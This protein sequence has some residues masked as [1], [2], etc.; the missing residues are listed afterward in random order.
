MV[1]KALVVG[2]YHGKLRELSSLDVDLTVVVPPSWGKQ[3]LEIRRASEY[4]ISILPCAL[5]GFN[6]F[7]YYRM[8]VASI[9][10]DLVHLDEEP[11]S[12]VTYQFMRACVRLHKPIVF[13]TWQNINKRYPPPFNYFEH[14]S[15]KHAQAAIAGNE[16]AKEILESRNFTKPI[17]V[18]PQFG[19]D[20]E[21]FRKRDVGDL[22]KRLGLAGKFSIGYI[23][24]IVPEK[25]AADLIQALA[26]LPEPCVLVL[27]GDGDFQPRAEQLAAQFGV[28]QRVRWVP[29]VSSLDIPDYMN[30]I[31]VLVLPSR[32]TRRWKEQFG[33]VLVEA[34]ACETPVVGSNSAEIP[35]V[36]G[37]AGLVFPEGDV[38]ALVGQLRRLNDNPELTAQWGAQGRA[39]VLENFTHRRIA[40]DTVGLYKQVLAGSTVP[41]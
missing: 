28:T 32:T 17:R 10:A 39:R 16:E 23:G 20:P 25:G 40:E 7:H 19:I 18:I 12:F 37:D 6:H 35:N 11:W 5:S 4:K 15:F 31:D 29:H 14:F 24:R 21:F 1:S 36:I 13:F 26:F 33:R 22:K 27:M 2:A 3:E 8:R 41:R 30:A 38:A 9:D 34:M